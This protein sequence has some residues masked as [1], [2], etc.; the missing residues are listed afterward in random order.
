MRPPSRTWR[1]DKEISGGLFYDWGAHM[2][3]WTLGLLEG[4]RMVSVSGRFQ[5]RVWH[6]ASNEDHVEAFIR[7]DDGAVAHVQ[8]SQ[9]AAAGKPRFYV[10]GTEGALVDNWAGHVDVS[11]RVGSHT[12]TFNV[13]YDESDWPAYYKG[14]ADHL[15]NDAPN[16]VTPESARRVICVFEL[17]ERSSQDGGEQPVPHE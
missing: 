11:A 4:R 13:D 16:P 9:I 2:V 7:F 17:A 14:L 10:L 12:A 15:V 5:K 1:G 6:E 8:V 3:D